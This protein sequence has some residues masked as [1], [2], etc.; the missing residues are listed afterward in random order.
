[1][2]KFWGRQIATN[3]R[4]SQLSNVALNTGDLGL[5]MIGSLM[6]AK[7]GYNSS[8]IAEDLMLSRIFKKR[9]KKLSKKQ[10]KQEMKDKLFD[11]SNIFV[12]D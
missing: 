1:M 4:L 12:V 8:K 11:L 9:Q 6:G 2:S 3:A 10:K 5:E 7:K